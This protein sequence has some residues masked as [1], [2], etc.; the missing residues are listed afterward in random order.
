MKKLFTSLFALIIISAAGNIFSQGRFEKIDDLLNKYYEYGLFNGTALVAEDGDVILSKGYGYANLEWNIP[1]TPDTKFRIGSISKQFT[2]TIIMR[3]VE[4]GKIKLDGKITDYL[5][6]YRKETGD[7]VTIHHLLTH[8]SGII[9]YTNT[10]N[11]WLDSL[12][13]H[14]DKEY[15]IKHFHSG[16]LEF[17]PGKEFSYNNTGY[18][19]LAIIA[20]KVTGKDFGKLLK[21]RIF[22]LV[23]MENTGS[24]DDESIIKKKAF[25]YLKFGNQFTN[26]LYM[27]M[28]NAMGAGH[29][30]STVEDLFKWDQALYTDKILSEESKEKMF[31]PFLSD[32]GYGW[33][34][35]WSKLSE[36]DSVRTIAH[37]GGINGFN[38]NFSRLVDK[39]QTIILFNNTGNAPLS[40]MSTEIAKILNNYDYKYPKKPIIDFLA[41][42]IDEKGIDE[43]VT[44]YKKIKSEERD[45]YDFSEA[46][47]NT[48]GYNYLGQDKVDIAIEIFRLNMEV[49]PDAFNTYDSY[50]E[51]LMVK[52]DKEGA[53]KYY[54]KSL[55]LNPGNTNG[56]NM[57]KKLGVDYKAKEIK[58]D[59]AL[60]MKYEGKYQLFPNFVITIRID[61]D[62]VFAQATG[63]G[64]FE[65]FPQS[66]TKFY[67]NVVPAQIE[68]I[69]NEN[70]EFNKMILFQNN[71]EMPG[72]RIN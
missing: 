67:Y 10:P 65:I 34:I 14:Y 63:Q 47:L 25:G 11:V 15:F 12:R 70:G 38:T 57:L 69:A 59:N 42:V 1:N 22:D 43:A 28:P 41:G 37:S 3:L 31:T 51:G 68:F 64:E 26:D 49:Y 9:S 61:G 72:E 53:I 5:P 71:Q 58:I 52:G 44:T 56:I 16:D 55:E 32:Y 54:E 45:D 19:L 24:E 17:E 33:G 18:Y 29:M 35:F 13:N 4:E 8:T 23:G 7:K 46:Q 20:E 48:L 6:D 30:Y 50:A 2:A 40:E 62:R 39:N 27:F 21:E 36:S 60:L 66:E